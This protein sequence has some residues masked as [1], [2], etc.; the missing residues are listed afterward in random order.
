L[1]FIFLLASC[2]ELQDTGPDY[3]KVYDFLFAN[4]KS[5]TADN[6]EAQV[7][8][9]VAANIKLDKAQHQR[10]VYL[11]LSLGIV[12][13]DIEMGQRFGVQGTPTAFING[14]RYEGAPEQRRSTCD[15]SKAAK[16]DFS[17]LSQTPLP[18]TQIPFSIANATG[19]CVRTK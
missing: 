13:K 11:D 2:A 14:V 9:F 3:S 6:I 7:L 15:H 19:Q 12:T 17:S 18:K 16:Q 1:D 8:G 5:L 4:Q 10:C